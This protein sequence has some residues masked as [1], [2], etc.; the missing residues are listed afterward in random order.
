[1]ISY[2]LPHLL[3]LLCVCSARPQAGEWR[4]MTPGWDCHPFIP[5]RPLWHSYNSRSHTDA[6][7][8]PAF[9][10]QE[11]V[12]G[13]WLPLRQPLLHGVILKKCIPASKIK[14]EFMLSSNRI[15]SASLNKCTDWCSSSAAPSQAMR[16]E[17]N[18]PVIGSLANRVV[19]PCHHGSLHT[20]PGLSDE[21]RVKW[22]KLEA[23][24]EKV[25][26]VAH[27]GMVKVGQEYVGRVSVP[28]HPLSVRDASLIITRLRTS[29]AGL[30]R[31]EVMNGMEDTRDAISLNVTGEE[32]THTHAQRVPV[33]HF[34]RDN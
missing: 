19:L 32:Y 26:L 9:L 17:K 14:A 33:L 2:V 30:Y 20:T 7:T 4:L 1:M 21:L 27:N 8:L 3:C 34:Y 10:Q 15:L 29:D 22:T 28:N 12:C 25:V 18:S 13:V 11:S 31:C 24:G 5:F 16:T 23:Q 6:Q